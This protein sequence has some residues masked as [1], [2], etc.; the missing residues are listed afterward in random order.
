M[1]QCTVKINRMWQ[2]DMHDSS[3]RWRSAVTKSTQS[4]CKMCMQRICITKCM[5]CDDDVWIEL[6]TCSSRLSNTVHSHA[7]CVTRRPQH[8]WRVGRWNNTDATVNMH[9]YIVQPNGYRRFQIPDSRFRIREADKSNQGISSL[10]L[11]CIYARAPLDTRLVHDSWI[12]LSPFK[13]VLEL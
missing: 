10:H 9:Q 8:V 3:I 11:A 13:N 1:T 6:G 5:Q 7:T 12:I 4:D 2:R